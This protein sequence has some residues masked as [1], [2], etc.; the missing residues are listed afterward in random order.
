MS[1][2]AQ[3][4]AA[5][6]SQ[7]GIPFNPFFCCLSNTF[8]D[9]PTFAGHLNPLGPAPLPERG[10]WIFQAL[11]VTQMS[12]LCFPAGRADSREEPS[13]HP[14]ASGCS[15]S[16]GPC[17]RDAGPPE[18]RSGAATT[19][20]P[21]RPGAGSP[22]RSPASLTAGPGPSRPFRA[23]MAAS[24]SWRAGAA[25]AAPWRT[26]GARGRGFESRPRQ[27]CAKDAARERRRV[28]R[29]LTNSVCSPPVN[30]WNSLEFSC[31]QQQP[32]IFAFPHTAPEEEIPAITNY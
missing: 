27:R 12:G 11:S 1:T 6:W 16:A 2:S 31:P 24:A 4:A 30:H 14:P 32:D 5:L 15:S 22:S 13:P 29:F 8:P 23:A 7:L 3:S 10:L 20:W 28:H 21:A 19:P 25:L 17:W 18:C 9:S 26:R